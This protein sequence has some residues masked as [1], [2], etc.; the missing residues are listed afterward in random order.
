[1]GL[2][3]EIAQSILTGLAVGCVYGIVALGFVLIYK[4]TEV[5]NFAQGEMMVLGAFF[6][7]SLITYWHFSYWLALLISSLAT[8]LLGT[9]FEKI[10]LRPLIGESVFPI[11]MLTLGLGYFIRASVNMIPQ[12][13]G[14]IRSIITPFTGKNLTF[15]SLVLPWEQ[16]A[17]II[18]TAALILILYFF[19]RFTRIGVGIRATSQN[20]LG[21]VYAGISVNRVFSL[22]WTISGA[23]GGFAGILLAPITFIH[24]NMGFIGLKAFPAAV[25]GGFGSVPGAMVGGVIIGISESLAGLYLPI[26]W[27]DVAAWIIL[28]LILILRPEGIFGI[29]AKKKV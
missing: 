12:W 15:S 27:K 19:F 11:I 6:S 13:G 2:L 22:T 23:V 21:A 24:M 28:V 20:Q 5:I 25:L 14:E 8:G 1:M 18:M 16:I 17:I 7:Y 26:G 4:A 10:L 9:L 29:Q 3:N